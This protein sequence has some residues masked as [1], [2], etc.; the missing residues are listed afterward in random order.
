M[1][2][3]PA[4]RPSQTRG[5]ARRHPNV[6]LTPLLVALLALAPLP[7]GSNRPVFWAL[8]A[9]LLGI[10]GT[11]YFTTLA[12]Q[13]RN[14]RSASPWVGR[15]MAIG[16]IYL[17]WM[18]VQILP[19]GAVLGRFET[20]LPSGLTLEHNTF[21]LAPGPSLLAAIRT[22]GYGMMFVLVLQIAVNRNRA[23]K[24]MQ[25][26]F[27]IVAGWAFY[28]LLALFQFGDSI[29]IFEK[30]AYLGSA[31]GPFVNR[32]AFATFLAMGLVAGTGLLVDRATRSA[33]RAPTGLFDRLTNAD[34]L[35][36]YLLALLALMVLVTLIQSNSRMGVLSGMLGSG[37]T[38]AIV[39]RRRLT[40]RK[41]RRTLLALVPILFLSAGLIGWGYGGVLF[42]RLGGVETD[43]NVRLEVYRQVLGMIAQRP[44]TG[45]GADSFEVVF[46][47]FRKP[48]VSVELNW[49]HAH[50]TYLAHWAETGV[51]FG[52]IPL[53]LTGSAFLACL[54]AGLRRETDFVLP[55][56]GAGV[57][58]AVAL[59]A[60]VDFGLEMQANVWLFLA[61]VALAL[62]G[63]RSSTARSAQNVSSHQI[64]RRRI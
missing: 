44:W 57:I 56:I 8:G 63:H 21:S 47:A 54:H 33:D 51:I 14:L 37:L 48:P 15:V 28:A 26:L 40:S 18:V 34:A 30:W 46:R 23:K 50:S 27:L 12:L 16:G 64:R 32:N 39:L 20:V 7:L 11:F 58:L 29:L 31:T 55:A 17:A 5:A 2:D 24:L 4:S 25:A 43:V 6:I 59:H 19:L 42:E 53:I 49:G 61:L 13:G 1:S 41:G 45:W 3:A 38:L 22:A 36:L 60:L 62:G 52:S 35:R 10:C 9:L